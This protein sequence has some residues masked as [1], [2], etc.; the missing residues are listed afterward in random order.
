MVNNTNTD[1]ENIE[2]RNKLNRRTHTFRTIIVARPEK[3]NKRENNKKGTE[4]SRERNGG[5]VRKR[6]TTKT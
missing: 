1:S 3:R 5:G 4:Q 2:K 6:K